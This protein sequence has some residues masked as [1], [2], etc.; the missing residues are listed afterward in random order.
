[1]ETLQHYHLVTTAEWIKRSYYSKYFTVILLVT[2][3]LQTAQAQPVTRELSDKDQRKFDECFFEAARY[4]QTNRLSGALA[5][6]LS[7]EEIDKNN[8]AV[9]FEIGKLYQQE[10]KTQSALSYLKRASELEPAN[11]WMMLGL[12]QAYLSADMPAEAASVYEKL[13]K[14]H[15]GQINYMFDLAQVYF[16]MQRYKDCLR[17]LNQVEEITGITEELSVQKKDIYLL[18][19]DIAGARMELEKL[20]E[21]Y[22]ASIEFMG[23]LAQ[24]YQANDMTEQALKVYQ[25]MLELAPDDPRAHLDLSKIY[26]NSGD[27]EKSYHHL[28][29]AMS[30]PDLDVDNKIQVLYSFYQL[31]ERDTTMRKMGYELIELSLATTPQE[32]KLYAM[33][34]DFLSRDNR[35]AEA[36]RSFKT[37]TRFGANQ[38][39]LWSE[40]M[41]LD[42]RLSWN[43]SLASDAEVFIGLYPNIPLGYL[44]AGSAYSNL[45]QYDKAISQLESGLDFVLDN[46]ELEEQFYVFLADANHKKENHKKSDEYFEKALEIN[47]NNPSTLNNYAY[48]LAIRGVRMEK[49]LEMTERSNTLAP[50]NGVFLDTWAWVLFKMGKYSEALVKIEECIRYGGGNSGEVIEHWGDILFKNNKVD[51]AVEKWIQA[52]KMGDASQSIDRKIKTRQLYD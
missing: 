52:E 45:R 51:E 19:D 36:R 31:S 8:P 21:A 42:A 49:A 40:I 25:Q 18:S 2:A 5:K 23:M 38:V 13:I 27:F 11:K 24:F 4:K 35:L 14:E 9:L 3:A 12:A 17:V 37:A 41:L 20:T 28:K 16:A 39:D 30:S 43:D 47:P 50:K 6:Y 33:Q 1:M 7:C 48:Y 15:P 44:M 22:P 10:G 26:R 29:I 34:G 46:P 32:P